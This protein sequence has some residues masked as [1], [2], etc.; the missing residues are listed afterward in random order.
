M[1]EKE[2]FK[3]PHQAKIERSNSKNVLTFNADNFNFYIFNTTVCLV[4]E[5]FDIPKLVEEGAVSN[6]IE[7]T[8]SIELRMTVHELFILKGKI[9]E[10]IQKADLRK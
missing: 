3:K 1:E 9:D 4:A 8:E 10:L 2:Q 7:T 6:T 5:K